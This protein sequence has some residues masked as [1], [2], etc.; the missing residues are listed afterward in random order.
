M[1]WLNG[2]KGQGALS[3]ISRVELS[4]MS[5]VDIYMRPIKVRKL[6]KGFTLLEMVLVIII[7]G[8]MGVGI[9]G[10]ISV[11]TQTYIS[12]TSRDELIGNARFAIERLSRE[13]RNAVPNS[14]R[15]STFD[16]S[17][18]LQFVPIAGS[19]A[20][21]D[22]PVSPEPASKE[23]T[24]IPFNNR[25]G[26]T[27]Q[28]GDTGFD[29]LVIAYPLTSDDI[30]TDYTA[31]MGKTF[32]IDSID[33]P[34]ASSLWTINV[35]NTQNINF[36]EDSP[37]ERLYL[38]NEQVS[39]CVEPAGST[40]ALIRFSESIATGN[41]VYPSSDGVYM[42][43]Y[44]QQAYSGRLP[45]DFQPATLKRNAVVQVYFEFTK[46]SE[47]YVFDHEIHMNNVP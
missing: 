43:G 7:M 46:D 39:Y 20:Y 11:S 25:D 47:D 8:I 16:A 18:C 45:F 2:K 31:A 12:A 22:I 24:V 17:H 27:Y 14:I 15:I 38:A 1:R 44:L 4:G 26:N 36:V 5:N 28:L 10:F 13:V 40:G 35:L 21:T 29:D 23:L 37:T 9:S 41:Q 6:S 42:A 33:S 34:S 19:T 32:Q 3:N 30:Y